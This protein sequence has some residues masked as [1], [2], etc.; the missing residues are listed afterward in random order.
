MTDAPPLRLF[1]DPAATP[2]AISSPSAVPHHWMA[3]VK[4]GLERDE[5]LG[6]I[7][8]VP[9]NDPIE[10]CSRMVIA[11]PGAWWTLAKLTNIAQDRPITLRLHGPLPPLYLVGKLKLCLIIGTDIIRYQFI[12]LIDP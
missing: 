9:V 7:E 2:V 8:K 3:D 5:R 11:A 4:A 1:V 6:V 12:L 10:W